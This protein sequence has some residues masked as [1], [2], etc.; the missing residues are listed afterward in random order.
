MRNVFFGALAVALGFG[1]G[2]ASAQGPSGR[3][4]EFDEALR[5]AVQQK[6][7]GILVLARFETK[8][9]VGLY[10]KDGKRLYEVE[11]ARGGKVEKNEATE[12]DAKQNIGKD[13]LDALANY[14]GAKLP[15]ARYAE[16]AREAGGSGVV[17]LQMGLSNGTLVVTATLE[18][19]G[20][21]T[22]DLGTGKVVK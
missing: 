21:V 16:I 2:A 13:V 20:K 4:A 1:L 14:R 22:M 11:I 8:G 17:G 18:G 5:V 12:S 9:R 10:F 6:P 15:Y 3:A 19:G 7:P